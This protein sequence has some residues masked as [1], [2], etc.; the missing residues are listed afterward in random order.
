MLVFATERKNNVEPE[1][2]K[3]IFLEVE[4]PANLN[5]IPN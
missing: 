4:F 2:Q 5:Q 3:V 1:S